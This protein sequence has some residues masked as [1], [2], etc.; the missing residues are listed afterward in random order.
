MP[1]NP[2]DI[3]EFVQR[4]AGQQTIEKTEI[5][6]EKLL[7]AAGTNA[8]IETTSCRCAMNEDNRSSPVQLFIHRPEHLVAEWPRVVARHEP[9]TVRLQRGHRIF[10]FLEAPFSVVQ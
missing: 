10:D 3:G 9:D 6:D 1:V 2:G 7:N 4:P 8:K 5:V